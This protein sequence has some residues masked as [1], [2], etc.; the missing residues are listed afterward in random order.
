[1]YRFWDTIIK[2]VIKMVGAQSVLEIGAQNGY[3][4][5][6]L[7]EYMDSIEGKIHSIDPYP[8]FDYGTWERDSKSE[9][10]MHLGL[11]LEVLPQLPAFDVYLIDGDHNW[12]T[13]YNELKVISASCKEKDVII[14]LHDIGWPYARRDLYY[15]P[16]NIPEKFRNDYEKKGIKYGYDTLQEGGINGE[17]Y[18]AIACNTPQNGVLTAIEDFISAEP[19]YEFANIDCC[20]GLGIIKKKGTYQ[21][22]FEYVNNSDTLRLLLRQTEENRLEF[23]QSRYD[24]KKKYN[25]ACNAVIE[26][27]KKGKIMQEENQKQIV[28]QLKNVTGLVNLCTQFKNDNDALRKET[29]LKVSMLQN[30]INEL[31]SKLSES[32]TI[33]DSLKKDND[34][35]CKEAENK[36]T[37]LQNRTCEL[38]NELLESRTM[39]QANEC[40]V[41]ELIS[42]IKELENQCNSLKH[43][44]EILREEGRKSRKQCR[45]LQKELQGIY[46]SKTFKSAMIMSKLYHSPKEICR[47]PLRLGITCAQKVKNKLQVKNVTEIDTCVANITPEQPL[48]GETQYM[49]PLISE[50]SGYNIYCNNNTYTVSVV[51]CIHNALNDVIECL[52]SVWDKRTFPYEIILIDDG[53]DTETEIYVRTFAERTGCKLHRNNEALGYTKSANIG[54]KM[55]KSDYVILL[56]SDTIVTDSWVEKM[57]TCFEKLPNT[58]IVSPLSN[59]ASYQS[60]PETK[61]AETG[62]WKINTL[63]DDMTVDMM[64]L[65]VEKAS[66]VRY[67]AVAALN[68]FCFM[69]SRQVIDTIG[70]LD[71]ENFPKGYGEE[72]DYCIRATKAGYTLRVVDDTYIFHE[73]SKSFTHKTRKELGASSKPVLKQK[74]GNMYTTIGKSMDACSE[75]QVI[76]DEIK[77]AVETYYS[78]YKNLVGKKIAFVLTAKGGSG[79]ANSV[80]QEVAGMRNLGIDVSVIN[81]QNYRID[82]DKNYPEIAK[83]VEYFD[84]KS[85]SSFESIA[86]K[87]DVLIATIF[88]TVNLIQKVKENYPQIKIGYYVQDYEP[89]FFNTTEEYFLEAKQSYTKIPDMCLFAKTKWIADTVQK[90]HSVKVNLV[91][92]SIDTRMYNPFVIKDK[93]TKEVINICAMIRPKTVRRNP[94]GTMKVL[95]C[96]KNQYGSYI[97]IV[98]FG[99]N[100]EELQNLGTYDFEYT[101][102]GILKRW[103]VAKLLAT[104]DIFLDMSTYQAFGR[105]GLE[106]MCLGCIPVL[107]KEGGADKFAI[108]DVNALVVDTNN[109]VEV[110]EKICRIID[111]P[112]KIHDLQING[113][114]AAKSFNIMN[115]AWSE[116]MLLNTLFVE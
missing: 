46:E 65:I 20:N 26:Q 105:T 116:I 24:Y 96:L 7:I 76:R 14:I 69:I 57:L 94:I 45:D 47:V 107:P 33:C 44:N 90:Y 87:Y 66:K 41:N 98:L 114:D 59:A 11:S 75:L 31:E 51:V 22:V 111:T 106:S 84:K 108:D 17:L 35:L 77:A 29:E 78:Q 70:Y 1:M 25:A 3:T 95:Q 82:F 12:Y 37:L 18:N 39:C 63:R 104:S 58:G 55:A 72:V 48:L 93:N 56:N 9:F 88:T 110:F 85:Y 5:Q 15:N 38:E 79:G 103:E 113:I 42:K 10:K 8:N 4:T 97:N 60:V 102:L 6:K 83:Y 89:Y 2:P 19:N 23:F 54:L 27:K 73:K 115:A 61:D 71:E 49:Y 109:D 81:S 80:C 30:K 52:N 62:D 40:K 28:E 32:K 50:Y 64:G 36:V 100:D 67:P 13:V 74:H 99:C 34:L 112:N 43:N 101:N 53:S 86:C 21:S 92:P 68:G 91:E 16:D